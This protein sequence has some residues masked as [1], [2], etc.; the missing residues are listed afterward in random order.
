MSFQD[1]VFVRLVVAR[2]SI[3]S[4]LVIVTG[5]IYFGAWSISFYPQIILNWQRKSVIGLNFDFL[6]LNI[7]G[8]F[9]YTIYNL[10]LYF[11]PIVQD[12]YIARHG[13][14]SLIPVLLNDV[15]FSGHAL[16]AC[17]ITAFQC[18]IY[19]RGTQ[20]ISYTC[21]IWASIL[22]GFSSLSLLLALFSFFNW[23]DFINYLSYVKMGVTLS[24]YFPQAILNFKRKSTIGWSIGNVLLDA[25]GGTMDIVQ[26]I[27]QAKNTADWS[28]F[29]GNPVKFGLGFVS[30]IFDVLFIIQH[31]V[32]YPHKESDTYDQVS[33]PVTPVPATLSVV[34]LNAN[35]EREDDNTHQDDVFV[36]LVVARSSIISV[37]VIVTGWI[38]FGAWSISFYPQII[39]NWQRKS[40]IGLNFD[41][42]LLNIIGFFCYTIY[43]L[44]LYFD[45]IVQD[46]YI[47]RH[48]N[49]SLIP[50]LLN[51]VI[52][53]GHALFACLITAFQC[54]IYERGTQR[55]SYTC[56]IWAS[57]LLGFSSLSLLLA[58]FSFFN[59]LDFI[60]YLSYVKMGV[61][62]SKYFPQ[63]I[64]NFKR[65]S[66]IGWSIGNVL[67]DA[68]GGTMDIVQ[69]ILQAKNTADW[70]AFVGNP[71]K[72]GLGFVSIIFDVLFI[73]QHYILYPHK[74]SDTYDQV[75]NPVTPV[76][77][78]LSVVGLNANLE[79][80]D[81]NTQFPISGTLHSA[82]K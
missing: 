19:E 68:T 11:D 24:K 72:F 81:D 39:L 32:L 53:S 21:R 61:T 77:A 22:L 3:I 67:L 6:L 25:T 63:A 2:S 13:N 5:W 71:V 62:L 38:Y 64:L 23:L 12:I 47:A 20:R 73:I 1:D 43:N 54:F 45:P 51:D 26:M 56:R 44:L 15:I 65:K 82:H 17:L 4:V 33:N 7:I 42:L 8:F 34:G 50:V 48:G 59:W 46:I 41:F 31:Y 58:L 35:L 28:A 66:T 60:N 55:I 37:L 70:S 52:F 80:E 40:V 30:I 49:R 57:I 18:F 16:F 36:R 9:C 79:R 29:V 78:T 14:R 27:L 74:E 69:M 10:L 75:S 76:P